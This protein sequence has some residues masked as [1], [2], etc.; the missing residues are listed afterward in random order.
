MLYQYLYARKRE[1]GYRQLNSWVN[2]RFTFEDEKTMQ[3]LS[4]YKYVAHLD[5]ASLP[6]SVFYY[7]TDTAYGKS[8]IIGKTS[9]VFPGTSQ[10]SGERATSFVHEYI[11][12]E[13]SYFELLKQPNIVFNFNK[14]CSLVED[15]EYY[16]KQ[17]DL[18]V[19]GASLDNT[20]SA[21]DLTRKLESLVYSKKTIVS[22]F[23]PFWMPRMIYQKDYICYY[24]KTTNLELT[25]HM[26]YVKVC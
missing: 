20:H 4:G 26:G 5:P 23:M 2:T 17:L 21:Y 10:E 8:A 9:Y 22:L 14:F 25:L 15:T 11:L 18:S 6:E 24:L 7:N 12:T 19:K 3:S 16:I 1:E 13:E